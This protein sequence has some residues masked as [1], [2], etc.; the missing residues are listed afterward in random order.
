MCTKN[1]F[2]YKIFFMYK[3]CTKNLRDFL[4]KKLVDKRFNKENKLKNKI[5]YNNNAISSI[6]LK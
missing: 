5:L 1:S 6:Y 2:L 3:I 4:E